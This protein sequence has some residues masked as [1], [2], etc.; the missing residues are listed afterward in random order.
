MYKN[1]FPAFGLRSLRLFKLRRR[2]KIKENLPA[3]LKK[4]SKQNSHLSWVILIRLLTTRAR[5]STFRFGL[6]YILILETFW[7]IESVFSI[8]WLLSFTDGKHPPRYLLKCCSVPNGL[9]WNIIFV[10]SPSL[11]VC[12]SH[13]KPMQRHFYRPV[14]L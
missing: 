10:R 2:N 3:K 4:D 12:N 7:L 6:I 13:N 11:G 8:L 5:R 14:Y 9:I 1:I